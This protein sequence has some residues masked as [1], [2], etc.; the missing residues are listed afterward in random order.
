M[1]GSKLLRALALCTCM[2][3]SM[4]NANASW[5][6]SD[7]DWKGWVYPDANNLSN[8]KFIGYFSTLVDCR[9]AALNKLSSLHASETGDYEC[10]YKCKTTPNYGDVCKKTVK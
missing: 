4:S 9:A 7:E 2:L 3:L 1:C 6:G 8:Y 10:G 5:F